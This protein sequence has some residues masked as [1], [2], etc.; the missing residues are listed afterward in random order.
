LRSISGNGVSN[1]MTERMIRTNGAELATEPFGDPAHPPLLLI[2]G[3]MA[4]MLWWPDEFCRKLA[5]HNRY[6][7][8]YDHRDTGHSTK[9]PPGNAPYT[10]DDFVKDAV[11]VL[12]EY[13]IAR[14]HIVGMS[15]GGMIGQLAAVGFPSRVLSLT[16]ISSTPVGADS[17]RLPASDEAWFE[18]QATTSETVDWSDRAQVIAFMVDDARMTAS[19]AHRF[20]EARVKAFIER[21][22]DRAGGYL[23]A[24]NHGVLM[25]EVSKR[26]LQ[27]IRVPLL[28]IHG[29]TDP[30]F[31]IEHGIALSK[32]VRGSKVTRIEGGG[33]ELHP[34]DWDT[35]IGAVI[36]H[37][38][39]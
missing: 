7:I 37:T 20:D 3:G 32:T 5:S 2:M 18:H 19:T 23:N 1:S 31:P 24:T 30:V 15:L 13:G 39:Q 16:V 6:V 4:S 28:V 26:R 25:S 21:D 12:D 14:A 22:Y 8:R 9:Y 11:G 34:A 29:T 33:H 38:S 27:E 36:A 35:I 10:L 17:S